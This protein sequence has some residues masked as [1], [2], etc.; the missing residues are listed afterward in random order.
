VHFEFV[1]R[2]VLNV[3]SVI[4]SSHFVAFSALTTF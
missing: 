2:C 1:G 3:E 4:W